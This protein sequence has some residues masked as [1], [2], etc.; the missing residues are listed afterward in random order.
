MSAK[1]NKLLIDTSEKIK[2]CHTC[3]DLLCYNANIEKPGNETV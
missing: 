3:H 2:S 1:V